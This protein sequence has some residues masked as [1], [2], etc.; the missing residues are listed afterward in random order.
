MMKSAQK[1]NKCYNRDVLIVSTC[2]ILLTL[3]MEKGHTFVY[4]FFLLKKKVVFL[5]PLINAM[6]HGLVTC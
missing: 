1:K 6:I 3:H 2:I 5:P 4:G